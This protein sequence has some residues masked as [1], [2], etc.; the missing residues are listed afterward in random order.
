VGERAGDRELDIIVGKAAHPDPDRRYASA[1]ALTNDL[2]RYLRGRPIQA[3]P[4]SVGYRFGK[5][6]RRHRLASVAAV[7]VAVLAVAFVWRLALENERAQRAEERA[8]QESATSSRVLEHMVALFDQASPDKAGLR[9]ITAEELVDAGLRDL[10]VR[11][12]GQ[13][14][15]RA[16]LLAA[17]AETYAK[18]GRNE[19]GIAAMEQAIAL[20]RPLGDPQWLSRYLQLHGNMLNSSGRFAAAVATLD[21]G[22]ALQDR[23][24]ARDPLL[25]A[26]MLTTRSLARSRSGATELAITDAMRAAEFARASQRMPT[27]LLGEA[28]NALSEA[29]LVSNDSA[30]AVAIARDNVRVLESRGDAGTTLFGAREYLAAALGANG[31]LAEAEV[32][33]RRQLDE[34]SKTLDIRSDWFISLRNQLAAVVRNL[35]KPLE[36]SALLRENVEAMRARGITG[37]PSYMIALNNLGSL[38]EHV[39]DYVASEGL[40]R[41]ALR[42]ALE[43]R[44][45]ASLRPDIYRQNLGRVLLLAGNYDEAL[46]LIE[47]EIVDDGSNDRRITRLRRLVHLAEWHRRQGKLETAADY[48][49]Q[50]ERNLLENFGAE[51]PR[52]GAVLLSRALLARDRGDLVAAESRLREAMVATARAAAPDSNPMTELRLDLADVLLRRGA[53]EE[54]RALVEHARASIAANF[55][56]GAPA[57]VLHAKLATQLGARQSRT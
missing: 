43:E 30:R 31:E 44:D 21:E 56:P 18:L 45:A 34:R 35:G 2:E 13:P 48:L 20:Q 38:E 19:K 37:T 40:L 14:Q 8:R 29:Y 22:I 42:L 36:A 46:P 54:A 3:A 16:R 41:E 52:A 47:H 10:D 11:F 50:A 23:D 51:H 33:L 57:R 53:R 17:L 15:A 5:F 26:E 4:D 1:E 55:K 49:D 12:D 24:G 32:L 28:N 27:V 25:M 9:P 6:V 7:V 39:G